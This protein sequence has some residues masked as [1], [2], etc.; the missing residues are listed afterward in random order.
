MVCCKN[1]KTTDQAAKAKSRDGG[2]VLFLILIAVALFAALSYAV[3]QSSRS[4]GNADREKLKTA[5]SEIIQYGTAMEQA[6]TRMRVINKTTPDQLSFENEAWKSGNGTVLYAAG[7]NVNSRGTID[8]LF[9]PD[10]GGLTPL[11]FDRKPFMA[12]RQG[13]LTLPAIGHMQPQFVYFEQ[14]G[15]ETATEIALRLMWLDENLC[16]AIND[17]LK[18]ENPNGKPPHA[19]GTDGIM[20]N[21]TPALRGRYNFCA[22]WHQDDDYHHFYWHVLW[23]R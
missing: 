12:P 18:I 11:T 17:I 9:H 23:A 21:E 3:T 19:N 20:T 16:M 15:T 13:A 2:N 22:E 14:I 6:I 10:G 8:Q 1:Q 7:Y 5:A 4:G